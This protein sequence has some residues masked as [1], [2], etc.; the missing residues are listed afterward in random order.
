MYRSALAIMLLVAVPAVQRAN[1]EEPS[2]VDCSSPMNTAEIN[3]C[4]DREFAKADE[5]LNGIFQKLLAQIAESGEQPPYDAKSWQAALRASQRA[6]IAF[7]DADCKGV[8]PMEWTGGSGTSAA[9]LQC[10]IDKT[11]VR[12]KELSERYGLR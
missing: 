2:Q 5:A 9:V 1:C 8:V 12:G 11:V 4:S 10:M 7:R 3:T 6:W